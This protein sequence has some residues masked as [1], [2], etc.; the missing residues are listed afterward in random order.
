M[1]HS[2]ALEEERGGGVEHALEDPQLVSENE[3][4]L[5]NLDSARGHNLTST[6][7]LS[8]SH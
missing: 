4:F 2:W 1:V 7:Y 5:T 8:R 3:M 6:S